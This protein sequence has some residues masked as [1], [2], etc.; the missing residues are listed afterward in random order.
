MNRGQSDQSD[1]ARNDRVD[2]PVMSLGFVVIG[3]VGGAATTE[4][5]TA[6]GQQSGKGDPRPVI[7]ASASGGGDTVPWRRGRAIAETNAEL[8]A[9]VEDTT[10]PGAGWRDAVV[11]A[12]ADPQVGAVWSKVRLDP[13]LP[14]R[15]RALGRLEY[16]R[17]D[18]HL[19]LPG[20]MPGNCFALRRTALP[21]TCTQTGIVEHEL[22][23]A[24]RARGWAIRHVDAVH[25]TYAVPDRYGARLATR[26]GHGRLYAGTRADEA[27][28]GQRLVLACKSPVVP[29]VLTLRAM[30][31]A[32]SAGPPRSW[33]A[34][35]P[36]IVVMAL[37][38]G[39]GEFAGA[40]FGVGRSEGSWR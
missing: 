16:G 39:A 8:I 28:P 21:E 40:V 11:A 31:R 14:A 10:L 13:D 25:A 6:L 2:P 24:M 19:P 29:V 32:V 1:F 12:F 27:G 15:Y 37:A 5:A 35:L 22:A 7:I 30:S 33:L 38:W 18:G 20:T 17:F 34:E 9:I 23:G 4:C 3:L 36:W 26:F